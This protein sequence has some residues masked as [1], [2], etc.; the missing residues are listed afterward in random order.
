MKVVVTVLDTIRFKLYSLIPLRS[1]KSLQQIIVIEL[2]NPF[3]LFNNIN[4]ISKLNG[5]SIHFGSPAI[6]Y[7]L[8]NPNNTNRKS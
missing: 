2:I 5:T 8:T 4:V 7:S 3:N 6:V 1:E